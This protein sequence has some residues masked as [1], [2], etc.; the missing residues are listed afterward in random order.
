MLPPR[1]CLTMTQ[2][3]S[4]VLLG[5]RVPEDDPLLAAQQF[6]P[7]QFI[8][9]LTI[10][11]R[12]LEIGVGEGEGTTYLSTSAREVVGVDLIPGHLPR[13]AQKYRRA[14]LSF[15]HMEATALRFPEA[16]FDVVCSFQTIERIP[17]PQLPGYLAEIKRVMRPT[18]VCCL[19]T[20]NLAHHRKRGQP[21]Q[22]SS[23]YENEFE[24]WQLHAL[25]L[26]FFRAIELHGVH[27]SRTQRAFHRLK[28][29]GVDRWLPRSVNPIRY[30]FDHATPDAFLVLPD[31]SS[32]ALDLIA[33][34]RFR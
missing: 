8:Q 23:S 29:W 27:P 14:N 5:G 31:F 30:Y 9:P 34:C 17:E 12:V 33:V 18:G 11:Q 26:D 28:R 21:Y 1:F 6:V 25:L 7:Y 16:S 22:K 24:A 32:K 10:Y 2:A 13:A 20:R 15:Q 3:Q 4:E 19:S